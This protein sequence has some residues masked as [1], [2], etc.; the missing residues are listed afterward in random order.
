MFVASLD[1]TCWLCFSCCRKSITVYVTESSFPVSIPSGLVSFFR[2]DNDPIDPV[3]DSGRL[4]SKDGALMLECGLVVTDWPDWLDIVTDD[5]LLDEEWW[6]EAEEWPSFAGSIGTVE[7]GAELV[8]ELE[9]EADSEDW[10]TGVAGEAETGSVSAADC[11]G[12]AE[13][14]CLLAEDTVA[15]EGRT[16]A[17]VDFSPAEVHL[18]LAGVDPPSARGVL[19][20][21]EADEPLPKEAPTVVWERG[22]DTED[23]W[24]VPPDRIVDWEAVAEKRA[25]SVLCPPV[26]KSEEC[27]PVFKGEEW[28]ARVDG[29]CASQGSSFTLTGT[30]ADAVED[31]DDFE[32]LLARWPCDSFLIAGPEVEPLLV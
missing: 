14:D 4:G 28:V 18:L 11:W 26:F 22:V 23:V 32:S 20:P 27:A 17:K 8:T 24:L 7:L 21:A 1:A 30:D 6:P 5:G 2:E 19:S 15:E 9:D 13:K 3:V 29:K 10:A 12:A 16:S 31:V 25:E